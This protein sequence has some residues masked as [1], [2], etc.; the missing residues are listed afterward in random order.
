MDSY[1]TQNIK[2]WEKSNIYFFMNI[3]NSNKMIT[4]KLIIIL[5]MNI[6]I[7]DKIGLILGFEFELNAVELVPVLF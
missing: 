5:F 7:H 6:L 1:F 3:N 4:C 2:F